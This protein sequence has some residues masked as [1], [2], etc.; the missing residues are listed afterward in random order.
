MDY[1]LLAGIFAVSFIATFG[2]TPWFIKKMWQR[3]ILGKDQNKPGKP[4]VPR[5]GGLGVIFGLV[6]GLLMGVGYLTMTNQSTVPLLAVLSAV[7]TISFI[8]LID[9]L[10]NVRQLLKATM[11][12]LAALPLIAV[13]AGN[14]WMA[15]PILGY[16]NLHL[17]YYVVVA[18]GVTGASN[19]TNMLAG[20]NGLETGL[21]VISAAA[22]LFI[23]MYT[24]QLQVAI[25]LIAMIAASLAFLRY[26]FYRAQAFP[27]NVLTYTIG[28][29]IACAAII[30]NMEKFAI[31]LIAPYF[32]ELLLKSRGRLKIV[33]WG[34]PRK[35]NTLK[36]SEGRVLSLPNLI[37]VL[38]RVT[39]R[40]LVL[41]L[42]LI[43]ILVAVATIGVF[44]L[45]L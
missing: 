2:I 42:Y 16:V 24:D 31:I 20:Y 17:L 9:D 34:T 43:Q 13:K 37:M 27:G 35:D 33:P 28:A 12:L 32:L 45:G 15:L 6:F 36:P 22:L 38:N 23:A 3:Q 14:T 4:D 40:K 11:P 26:N 25:I 5:V 39:E 41:E 10:F 21:G 18:I 8:G 7:L 19:A 30:G 1:P 29:V 44:F